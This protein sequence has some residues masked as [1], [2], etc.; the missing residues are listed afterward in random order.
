MF[1]VELLVANAL[2]S[3]VRSEYLELYQTIREGEEIP[4]SL[5]RKSLLAGIVL[6]AGASRYPSQYWM[7]RFHPGLPYCYWYLEN[8]RSLDSYELWESDDIVAFPSRSF[9]W[10]D[11]C[12]F[13]RLLFTDPS[14][15]SLVKMHPDG[16]DLL[17]YL[18]SNLHI[19]T[20]LSALFSLEKSALEMANE[21]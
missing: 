1:S 6:A 18:R 7:P 9:S 21:P 19:V 13:V 2:F 14:D 8:L 17:R 10:T 4:L 3:A 16:R 11:N 5:D 15:A 20:P 12:R